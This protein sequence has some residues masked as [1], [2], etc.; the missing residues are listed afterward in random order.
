M[1]KSISLDVS[2]ELNVMYNYF[3]HYF[4]IVKKIRLAE[5]M[6][7]DLIVNRIVSSSENI[8]TMTEKEIEE[9]VLRAK[10]ISAFPV[11]PF[12][13]NN[14]EQ[15]TMPPF[16]N[17]SEDETISRENTY[18]ADSHVSGE[19]NNSETQIVPEEH[20]SSEDTRCGNH[21]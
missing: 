16:R 5:F 8:E 2:N 15:F 7:Q 10:K 11:S 6:H 13:Q 1:K 18:P 3:S 12:A 17:L 20:N 9:H 21:A 14:P 19:H 4:G